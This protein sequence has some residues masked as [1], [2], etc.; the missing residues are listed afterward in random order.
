MQHNP[1][2][3]EA[4]RGLPAP[5]SACVWNAD[6]IV[7]LLAQTLREREG[8]LRR[9]QAFAG[10]DALQE[11]ELH[12]ILAGVGPLASW[13]VLRE[14]LYPAQWK[15]RKP[16]RKP[17]P[18]DAERQRCD[19][20]LTPKPDQRLADELKSERA[21]VRAR[22]LVRGTLFESLA[23]D[24]PAPVDLSKD[25]VVLPEDA[26][27]LE[28]KA[29]GQFSYVDGVPGPN[30]AYSSQLTRGVSGDLRKLMADT[31]VRRGGALLVHFTA[32]EGIAKH[33]LGVLVHRLLDKGLVIRPP[34]T[35]RVGILDRVGNA[36]C[37][38]V[39]IEPAGQMDEPPADEPPADGSVTAWA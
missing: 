12:P 23:T 34:A 26:Y 8:E 2:I 28:V 13:G 14:V 38:L 10:L 27:W 24:E 19:V 16:R 4:T 15:S 25:L 30:P 5:Y 7:D 3:H 21:R 11:T 18:E 37:T 31:S 33:D 35:A 36:V 29:V 32:D 6:E 20:V 1:S 9:E 39:L 17:L 22:E